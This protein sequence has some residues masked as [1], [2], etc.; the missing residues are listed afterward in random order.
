MMTDHVGAVCLSGYYQLRD[1]DEV[2]MVMETLFHVRGPLRAFRQRLS[3]SYH[4]LYMRIYFCWPQRQSLCHIPQKDPGF[5]S[6]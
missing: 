6:N 2:R 3:L 5:C 1:E 4:R